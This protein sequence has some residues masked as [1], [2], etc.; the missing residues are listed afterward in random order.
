MQLLESS[1]DTLNEV[2]ANLFQGAIMVKDLQKLIEKR[3][4][5]YKLVQS[6]KEINATATT[7]TLDLREKELGAYLETCKT[8][9][10]F[11]SYSIH[12][13]G[14]CDLQYNTAG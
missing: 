8:M 1:I 14:I 6:V 7:L 10:D 3:A 13:K 5:F 9:K 4:N 12:C 2:I 11:L